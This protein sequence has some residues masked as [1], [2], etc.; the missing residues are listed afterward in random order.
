L[1]RIEIRN[2]R[3]TGKNLRVKLREV[4]VHREGS[5]PNRKVSMLM[6]TFF[7]VP[8]VEEEEEVE[9]LN[10]SHVERMDTSLMNVQIRRKKVVKLTSPKHRGRMLRQKMLKV[11]DR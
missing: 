2:P 9:W 3:K 6:E 10:A 1:P 8:E 4:E 11:E 5:I 7:L